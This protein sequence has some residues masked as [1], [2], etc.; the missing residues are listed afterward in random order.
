MDQ[1][2]L[3]RSYLGGKDEW[4]IKPGLL[5]CPL[6]QTGLSSSSI[7]IHLRDGRTWTHVGG[8]QERGQRPLP[9][10]GG[11]HQGSNFRRRHGFIPKKHPFELGQ[12]SEG[13]RNILCGLRSEGELA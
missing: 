7:S 8:S 11:P 9:S 5:A 10:K 13:V 6:G 2:A 12:G 4:R 3:Q 1:G